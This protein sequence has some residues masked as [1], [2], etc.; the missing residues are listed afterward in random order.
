MLPL[1]LLRFQRSTGNPLKI[2]V[3]CFKKPEKS[4]SKSQYYWNFDSNSKPLRLDWEKIPSP[5]FVGCQSSWNF[6]KYG[7]IT[8]QVFTFGAH[9]TLWHPC[10][11]SAPG[12][13]RPWAS[14]AVSCCLGQYRVRKENPVTKSNPCTAVL[15]KRG[16][17]LSDMR[18]LVKLDLLPSPAK[19]IIKSKQTADSYKITQFIPINYVSYQLGQLGQ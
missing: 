5:R 14:V 13:F 2:G 8:C 6:D 17:F 19:Q 7:T 3:S 18:N 9:A 16:N 1:V 12:F 4:G 11:A 15:K 10:H